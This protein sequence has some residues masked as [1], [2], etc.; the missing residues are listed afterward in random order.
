MGLFGLRPKCSGPDGRRVFATNSVTVSTNAPP[1]LSNPQ[2]LAG[3]GFS[4]SL[5]GLPLATYFI[6][7][8]T[9]LSAWATIATN[10]LPSSGTLP[11]TDSQA[12]AFSR[13]YY[14]A[15]KAP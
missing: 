4:F 6:Q 9:N 14:R 12:T 7:A 10:T 2:R 3:G 13:R 5:A 1:Q 11:I 15:I 8:S